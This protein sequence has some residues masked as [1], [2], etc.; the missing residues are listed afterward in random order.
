MKPVPFE[1]HRAPDPVVPTEEPP[2]ENE[3][4]DSPHPRHPP[5]QTPQNDENVPDKNPSIFS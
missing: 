4:F 1:A 2:P 5:V 3:T